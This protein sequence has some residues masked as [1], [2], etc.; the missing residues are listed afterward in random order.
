MGILSFSQRRILVLIVL[1]VIVVVLF[2]PFAPTH[3]VSPIA[4]IRPSTSLAAAPKNQVPFR[5]NDGGFHW[6]NVPQK[7][8]V[9]SFIP[10][11]TT[12]PK[13][14]PEIQHKF[15]RER[16]PEREVREARLETIRDHFEHAWQGYRTRAWLQDE[17]APLSG[18]YN[19]IFGGWAA[20]MI[21]A[22]GW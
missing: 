22:L 4:I 1:L 16:R 2:R 8:P 15:G 5:E 18:G 14:I 21:D 9:S 17:V 13:R 10:L 3:I 6:S 20:S 7:Y 11:P 12:A 19:N